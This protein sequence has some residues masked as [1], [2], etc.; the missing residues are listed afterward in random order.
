MPATMRPKSSTRTS[1]RTPLRSATA[2]TRNCSASTRSALRLLRRSSMRGHRAPGCATWA[3]FWPVPLEDAD[4][5][6]RLSREGALGR[7]HAGGARL[8]LHRLAQ[9][10]RERLEAIST[11]WC[12]ISPRVEHDVQVALRAA[13]ERLEEHRRE[14]D[15]PGPDL[16]PAGQRHLPDE[17][18]PPREIERAGDARLVHRQRRP[19][20]ADDARLVAERLGDALPEDEPQ[21][22]GRVVA[23]DLH[24]ARGPHGQVDQA[25]A[26]DLL[27]HV[28]QEGQ[29][30]VDRRAPGPVEIRASPRCS[31]PSSCAT[32]RPTVPW[33][34]R[35]SRGGREQANDRGR[36][37]R[38]WCIVV[39]DGRRRRARLPMRRPR[40]EPPERGRPPGE[41]ASARPLRPAIRRRRDALPGGR[42]GGRGVPGPRG[43]RAPPQAR[44]DGRPQPGRPQGGRSL[45]RGRPH[46][47]EH[48]RLDRRGAHRRRRP[49]ARPRDVP[50]PAREAPDGRGPRHRPARAAHA[51][52][53]GSDRDDDAPRECS[54]R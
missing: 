45:R 21:V 6:S 27:D 9:R 53:R 5:V 4:V 23:V 33:A 32:A 39:L 10:P 34:K 38:S 51:R 3:H 52:R 16:G 19:P 50:R 40:P 37:I 17:E 1:A 35:V 20:V 14:L 24:V 2:S 54:R 36:R 30:R 12:R 44:G 26:G 46:R 7:G 28:R 22:L 15:V 13:R 49:R 31:S 41:R 18:R 29:R 42:A 11:M 8:D 47:G 43:T 48:L 25:V